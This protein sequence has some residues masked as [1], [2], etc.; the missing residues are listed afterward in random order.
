M[1]KL[2]WKIRRKLGRFSEKGKGA[3]ARQVLGANKFYVTTE[4][5]LKEICHRRVNVVSLP[6]SMLLVHQEAILRW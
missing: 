5:T 4:L 3:L 2:G 6:R 1:V